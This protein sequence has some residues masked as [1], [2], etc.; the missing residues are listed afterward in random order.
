MVFLWL[1]LFRSLSYKKDETKP[2]TNK[3]FQRDRRP[4]TAMVGFYNHWAKE[5]LPGGWAES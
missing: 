1:L 3:T 4:W 2:G 5:E